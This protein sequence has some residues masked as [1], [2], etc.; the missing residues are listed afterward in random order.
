[1]ENQN[2][3]NSALEQNKN[4]PRRSFIKNMGLTIGAGVVLG[5][6]A[7]YTAKQVQKNKT[8][9]G[10]GDVVKVMTQDGE[11]VEVA[12]D[13]LKP[14]T[15]EEQ[16]ELLTKQQERG[17]QGIFCVHQNP[18]RRKPDQQKN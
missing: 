18:S 3:E 17:R 13:D 5:G 2:K 14:L 16:K 11:L 15:Q 8:S 7:I 1:M 4:N 9:H 12:K 10:H 6:G